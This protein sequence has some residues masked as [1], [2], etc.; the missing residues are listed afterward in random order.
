MSTPFQ[1]RLVGTIIVAA[2]A[3]IVLPDL[4]DGNKKT[5][6]DE[7]EQIPPPPKVEFVK[8]EKIFPRDKAV[9]LEIDSLSDALIP[10]VTLADEEQQKTHR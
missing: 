9:N 4:L 10:N 2:I 3:I 8:E 5:F 7:F 6:Q 1:N